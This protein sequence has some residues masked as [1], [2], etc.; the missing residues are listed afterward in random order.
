DP[1]IAEL[2]HL[3]GRS[4]YAGSPCLRCSDA[5]GNL[6]LCCED[7]Q[8]LGLYC[9]L[10]CLGIHL[11]EP[12]HHLQRWTGKCFM[13]QLFQVLGFCFQLGHAIGIKCL[14]VI[15]IIGGASILLNLTSIYKINVDFCG[16]PGALAFKLQILCQHWF[17]S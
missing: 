12:M 13:S 4:D 6:G 10:C 11:C 15:P 1:Y 9:V 16:C 7:C 17:P 8:D 5:I 3:E 2:L 14:T